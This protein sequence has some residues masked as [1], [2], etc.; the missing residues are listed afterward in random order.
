LII[1]LKTNI[2][3]LRSRAYVVYLY[4]LDRA[5]EK[6]RTLPIG[7]KIA[8]DTKISPATVRKAIKDSIFR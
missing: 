1:E 5:N 4:L 8:G 2:G 6:S 3:T 7:K